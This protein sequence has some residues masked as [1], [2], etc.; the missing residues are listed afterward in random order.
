M[1]L[2]VALGVLGVHVSQDKHYDTFQKVART[3]LSDFEGC[4]NTF[5]DVML[6]TTHARDVLHEVARTATEFE[7]RLHSRCGVP[8]RAV[9]CA[10]VTRHHFR[11][12]SKRTRS[13]CLR[14]WICSWPTRACT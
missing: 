10:H 1:W 13:W 9:V 11:D 7:V 14:L 2:C 5:A 12:S 4:V 8:R 6:F 3:A